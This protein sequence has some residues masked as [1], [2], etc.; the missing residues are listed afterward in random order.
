[1]VNLD[2]LPACNT[3]VTYLLQGRNLLEV[4]CSTKFT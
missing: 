4:H 2:K 1:M 3:L